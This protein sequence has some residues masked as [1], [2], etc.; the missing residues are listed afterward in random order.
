MLTYFWNGFFH[1]WAKVHFFYYKL[2]RACF[3]N[4]KV[5]LQKLGFW[6]ALVKLVMTNAPVLAK[7]KQEECSSTVERAQSLIFWVN[8]V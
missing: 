6:Q 7:C 8:I 4:T 1:K 2:N 3:Q 5:R